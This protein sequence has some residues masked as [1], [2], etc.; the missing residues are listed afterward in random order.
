MALDFSRENQIVESKKW[1]NLKPEN[2][3]DGGGCLSDDSKDLVR[4]Y[5]NSKVSDGT[6]HLLGGEIQGKASR[7]R[8][9]NGTHNWSGPESN[10]KRID[11]GTH[12]FLGMTREKHHRYDPTLYS[13]INVES[14]EVVTLTKRNF[15]AIKLNDD[16]SQ[17]GNLI[18][19]ING[20]RKRIRGW[21]L[22]K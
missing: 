2:G 19:M 20:R 16:I 10:Q 3:L 11:E 14:G 4:Q 15:I 21:E 18:A 13:F 6:H 8:V 9:N 5:Q 1:A 22:V 7:E 17:N 12:N